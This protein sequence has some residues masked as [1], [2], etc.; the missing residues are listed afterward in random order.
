MQLA[1]SRLNCQDIHRKS[2]PRPKINLPPVAETVAPQEGV[3][4][5]WLWTSSKLCCSPRRHL[6]WRLLQRRRQRWQQR[7]HAMKP[8]MSRGWK[9]N[10][11]QIFL[12]AKQI[13]ADKISLNR[14]LALYPIPRG[15]LA[16]FFPQRSVVDYPTIL[17]TSTR[18]FGSCSAIQTIMQR[19]EN[20]LYGC[21]SFDY[22]PK[23][24]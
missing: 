18:G 20:F 13:R 1:R 8:R 14:V 2:Q 19:K 4:P 9:F 23:Y 10:D 11:K 17:F 24:T 16:Q 5:A 21:L 7:G 3:V 22:N 6:C 12:T 15:T